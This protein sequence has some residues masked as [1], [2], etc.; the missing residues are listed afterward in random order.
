MNY[1]TLFEYVMPLQFAVQYLPEIYYYPVPVHSVSSS[2]K[3]YND[4]F[5][6]ICYIL[7]VF[8]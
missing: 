1:M 2:F 8:K 3:S 6:E 7:Y 5:L 4:I